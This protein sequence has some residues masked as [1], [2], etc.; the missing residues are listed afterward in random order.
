MNN[1]KEKRNYFIMILSISILLSGCGS[2]TDNN[3][4]KVAKSTSITGKVID[5]E[6]SGATIFLDLNSD[7]I[8]NTNEPQAKSTNDGTFILNI[9]SEQEEHKNYKNKTAPLLAYGGTDIRTDEVFE[10]YMSSML[11]G[12]SSINITP[13]TTL[14]QQSVADELDENVT[15]STEELK[16]KIDEIKSNLSKLLDIEKELLTKDPIALAKEGDVTLLNHSLQ[17]HKS[18][19]VMKKAMAQDV[20]DLKISILSSYRALAKEFKNLKTASIE[21]GNTALTQVIDTCLDT[22]NIFNASLISSIKRESKSLVNDINDFWKNKNKIWI[23]A[24]LTTELKDIEVN[25]VDIDRTSNSSTDTTAP[26][27]PT[28]TNVP[29]ITKTD[30]TT[31]EINGEIGSKVFINGVENVTIGDTGVV[32]L[33]LDTSGEYGTKNFEI[34]LK[35]SSNNISSVLS[36]AIERESI[37]RADAIKLLRQA[38]FISDENSISYIIE[39]GYESWIDKQLNTIGDLDNTNDDKY[40]YL[41]S[42]LRFLHKTNS[43]RYPESIIADPY[44]NLEEYPDSTR[45][46]I[47]SKSI[48]WQKALENED[49]LRQ[50]VTYALS[51]LLVVSKESPAGGA[52]NMRG[53][54][55]AHYYDIL[56][57]NAFGNYRDLL[58]EVTLSPAMPYYLTFIGSSK[59]NSTTGTAPDENYARELMQLF[60][61]GLYELNLDGTKKLGENS[62]PIPTYTQE[63]VSQLAKVF[64]GWDWQSRKVQ[65]DSGF[66]HT[67]Y[68]STNYYAHSLVVP[69]KFTSE[70]HDFGEKLVL[71]QSIAAGLSGEADIDRVIDILMSNPNMAPLVSKHLIMRMVTSNPTP[72]YVK[73]VSSVF[74]NNGQGVK[75]DLRAT[76]R[77]IL[78]DPEARGLYSVDNFGKVEEFTLA[79]THF[80]SN[81]NIKPLPYFTFF[82]RSTPTLTSRFEN[83][84]WFSPTTQFFPQGALMAN[85]VFNFYSPE[86]IPSDTYFASNNLVSPEMQIRTNNNLI[87]FS[88][89]FFT[90][91][92][93]EKYR[94]LNIGLYNSSNATTM[95]E[96]VDNE[97]PNSSGFKNLYLDLTDVYEYFET[98]IEGDTNGDFLNINSSV[99]GH[100]AELGAVGVEATERLIDYIYNR[101]VGGEMPNDYKTELLAHLKTITL[102][103]KV[104]KAE[105][106]I[107]TIIRAIATSPLYMVL[108]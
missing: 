59:E 92:N 106:I 1:I 37:K 18:A 79:T 88:K 83:T 77:A 5:G 19:K 97:N 51:Q 54:A 76:V 84:Y 104:Y 94:M 81:F 9:T 58:K 46:Q 22:N 53:E 72:A 98:Q 3:E 15:L 12:N 62:N 36:I 60:T 107:R 32:F 26:T 8:L 30:T 67:G 50:R 105:K 57:K 74:N 28:V 64:T 96:W 21:D 38:S 68:G 14:I 33:N 89:M 27:T 10:D 11:E 66:Y 61:I 2:S 69:I 87:G 73:R 101:M 44:A 80:F 49:Q 82:M 48:W 42:L 20:K 100:K 55:L 39:N 86:F 24:D 40:G 13:L 4:N 34:S 71:G 108:K 78:I 91:L 6:I 41:E 56:A 16:N 90:L 23:N 65:G 35:D 99:S 31:I 103:N 70:Y 102:H 43:T 85:S 17:I 75:G 63:D 93:Y 95:T 7:G 47:F 45:F 25:V 52:L 29:T